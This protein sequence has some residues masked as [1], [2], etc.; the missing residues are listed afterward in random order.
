M[1][2]RLKEI[3]LKQ[4]FKQKDVANI[5]NVTS[6]TYSRYESGEIQPEK[7]TLIKLADFF[8][9]SLDYLFMRTNSP[10]ILSDNDICL[11][12]DE[13]ILIKKYRE[14]DSRGKKAVDDT[15]DREYSFVKKDL[16]ENKIM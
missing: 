16:L 10:D 8:N 9:V 1:H 11:C 5:L 7:N 13:K 14:L 2:N 6:A 4:S 3:R 15:I 12:D